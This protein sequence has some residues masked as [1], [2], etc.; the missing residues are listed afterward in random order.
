MSKKIKYIL[1]TILFVVILGGCEKRSEDNASQT[2][3]ETVTPAVS[4]TETEAVLEERQNQDGQSKLEKV[5]FETVNADEN[6]NGSKYDNV[7]PLLFGDLDGD[8]ENELIA[9][10]GRSWES[11]GTI[12]LS[13][14]N[15]DIWFASGDTAVQ[16]FDREY[17]S[18]IDVNRIDEVIGTENI[19]GRTI[20]RIDK[21]NQSYEDESDGVYFFE[22]SES[23]PRELDISGKFIEVTDIGNG[24]FT[25][26]AEAYDK[27]GAGEGYTHKLYWL[28]FENGEFKEYVG[29]KITEADFMKYSGGK[30]VLDKIEAEGGNIT[31]IIYRKNNIVNINYTEKSEYSG[32]IVNKFIT[33][34]VSGGDCVG[35]KNY[36]RGNE[37][38][39]GVYLLSVLYPFYGLPE[40][41]LA[42]HRLIIEASEKENAEIVSPVFG[43]FDGDGINE[44]IAALGV[45][46]DF[47]GDIA[48]GEIWFASGDKAECIARGGNW[49][50]P[51]IVTSCGKTFIKMEDC[52][53][54]ASSISHYFLL[55]DSSAS[56][57]YGVPGGQGVYPYGEFGDFTAVHDA[58]DMNSDG[59]GHTWKTYWYYVLDDEPYS[60]SGRKITEEDFLEYN[61]AKAVIDEAAGD[62]RTV[63]EI[64]KRGNGIM[65]VNLKKTYGTE[66]YSAEGYSNKILKYRSGKLFDITENY[67]GGGNY[68]YKEDTV[69]TDFE[70]FGEMIYDAAEGDESSFIRER[71]YGDVD[72]DGKNELYAYYGT[73]GNFSLWFADGSGAKKVTE[74]IS[75]FCADGNVLM[76]NGDDYFIIKNGKSQ[77]LDPAGAEDF[78]PQ[79]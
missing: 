52:A 48:D 60:Y 10:Y 67:D 25:A 65:T 59:T 44:V 64:I 39:S 76:K 47:F 58:Y 46:D 54:A 42:L 61:G 19:G 11:D 21:I 43:D 20:L 37:C 74:D 40:E 32:S 77:K 13:G 49:L 3:S 5:I 14:N 17:L 7:Y 53:F 79:A 72:N 36:F 24:V 23:S 38:N 41:Q 63:T 50:T 75:L 27:Y 2:V 12:Y 31:E 18:G 57:Y 22:I 71:F 16:L 28:Y 78:S 70:R 66:D 55:K 73:D 6:Y 45:T 8:G 9:L 33:F 35:V 30:A 68:R 1:G 29:E 69:Q 51:K 15:G 26:K 62:G 56:E 4:N 34:D